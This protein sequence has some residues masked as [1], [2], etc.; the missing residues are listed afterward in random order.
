MAKFFLHLDK[1]LEKNAA[2]YFERAKKIKRKILGV[3]KILADV[4]KRLA[5]LKQTELTAEKEVET[6]V[7]RKTQ[8]FEKFRWFKSSDGFLCIGGK[9]ASSNEMVVKKHTDKNDLVFHTEIPGSPFFVVKSEGGKVPE[10]TIKETAQATASYSKAWKLGVAVVDVFYVNPDQVSKEAKAGEYMAKGAFMIYGKRNFVSTEVKLAVGIM[11]D[12]VVMGGPV[13][14]VKKWCKKYSV[15]V[16]G[17]KKP[18]DI[19]KQIKHFIGG[20]L[21]DIMRVLPAGDSKVVSG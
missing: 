14:A 3:K 15:I 10:Q 9:D 17:D 2:Y 1:S 5:E 6:P 19:A 20:E 8:W 12:G 21:D 7:A 4:D 11:D 18:S 16:S 13:D